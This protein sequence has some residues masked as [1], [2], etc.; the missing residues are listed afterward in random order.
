[1]TIPRKRSPRG[2]ALPSATPCPFSHAGKRFH[3]RALCVAR[4]EP[5]RA[6]QVIKL[7]RAQQA[8]PDRMVH[9]CE[10]VLQEPDTPAAFPASSAASRRSP[11]SHFHIRPAVYRFSH[12]RAASSSPAWKIRYRWQKISATRPSRHAVVLLHLPKRCTRSRMIARGDAM[13]AYRTAAKRKIIA[14]ST[15]LK[16]REIRWSHLPPFRNPPYRKEYVVRDSS[17]T[18]KRAR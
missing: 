18:K 12:A 17:V 16:R 10:D 13:L 15:P 7:L 4:R 5:R 6:V 9:E 14:C 8:A 11:P 3:A 2:N 1:M